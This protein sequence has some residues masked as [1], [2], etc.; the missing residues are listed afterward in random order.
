MVWPVLRRRS[1]KERSEKGER[2]GGVKNSVLVAADLLR[3][4]GKRGGGAR[5]TCTLTPPRHRTSRKK[6]REKVRNKGVRERRREHSGHSCLFGSGEGRKGRGHPFLP[7]ILTRQ[8]TSRP[9]KSGVLSYHLQNKG[10][11]KGTG[12][13]RCFPPASPTPREKGNTMAVHRRPRM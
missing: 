11:T 12:A 9:G 1:C 4:E 6:G 10:I 3:K 5:T 13:D 7:F 2:G 8:E